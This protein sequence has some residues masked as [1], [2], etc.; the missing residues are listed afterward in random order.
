MEKLGGQGSIQ[1]LMDRTGKV[2]AS[3][4][5][6]VRGTP[7]KRDG[8]LFEHVCE[9][10]TGQPTDHYISKPMQ[11]GIE[12]EPFARMKY[13]AATGAIVEE[14]GFLQHPD[15]PLVG[16]SPDGLVG[17]D[18]IIECKCP[19]APTHIRTL[20]DGMSSDHLPQI[21][22]VLW[23]TGRKWADFISY[24]PDLPPPLDLHIQRVERDEEY[25]GK[26]AAAVAGFLADAETLIARLQPAA[27]ES[28]PE[29]A[30]ESVRP[31]GE[32]VA[33]VEPPP[34]A[35]PPDDY[36]TPDQCADLEAMCGEYGITVAQLKKAAKV[37]RLAMLKAADYP[38]ALAWVR[39]HKE[40]A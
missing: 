25:I 39:K 14:V 24:Y 30:A 34:A 23:I 21:Q 17:A 3:N 12:R 19:T 31:A 4:F 8:Y 28:A 36:I 33:P 2:T 15:L 37:D 29:E 5:G 16:G 10:L 6:K 26:L 35:D 18:G 20:I 13:E 38:R 32:I 27:N 9:R 11:D 22:G 1:W 7:A 40:A